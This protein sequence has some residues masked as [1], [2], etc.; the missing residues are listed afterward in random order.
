[1]RTDSKY[2]QFHNLNA[3]A[4]GITIYVE[5]VR[6]G[7]KELAMDTM[8]IRKNSRLTDANSSMTT[9]ISDLSADL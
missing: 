2:T 9:Q 4:D 7:R 8:Y 6:L 1:M 5:E 3:L